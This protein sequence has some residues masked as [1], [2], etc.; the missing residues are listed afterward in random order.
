MTTLT[1]HE[2]DPAVEQRLRD[3][4]APPPRPLHRGRG[5]AHPTE[6]RRQHLG[7]TENR[8]RHPAKILKPIAIYEQETV[9]YIKK[10]QKSDSSCFTKETTLP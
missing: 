4:A 1:I 2:L 7:R 8:I 9:R 3:R 10:G 5:Q 6:R